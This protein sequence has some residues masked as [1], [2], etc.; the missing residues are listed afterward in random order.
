MK[1]HLDMNKIARGL[2]AERKGKV[3]ATA[4]TSARYSCWRTSRRGSAWRLAEDG[5]RTRAGRNGA[6]CHCHFEHS[7]V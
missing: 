6:L 4:A 3:P 5:Q 7:S 2:G 1:P